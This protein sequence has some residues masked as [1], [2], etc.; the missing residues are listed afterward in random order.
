MRHAEDKQSSGAD[1][2]C[3]AGVPRAE[4]GEETAL[5]SHVSC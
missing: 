3:Q 5:P 4:A 1:V 2:G